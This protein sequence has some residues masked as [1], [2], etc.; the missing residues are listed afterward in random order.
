ML[1]YMSHTCGSCRR[2]L[3]QGACGVLVLELGVALIGG[4]IDLEQQLE[5]Q[6]GEELGGGGPGADVAAVWVWG[7]VCEASRAICQHKVCR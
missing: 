5:V 4:P 6:V 3:T 1:F 2:K 7:S